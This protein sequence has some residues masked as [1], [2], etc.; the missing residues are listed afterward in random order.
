MNYGLYLS[1]AGMQA[2]QARQTVIS[3]NLANAQTTGFKRDLAVMRSRLN[4]GY[5]DATMFP[6]RAPVTRDQGGGVFAVNGGIDLSQSAL[7]DS[8]S[9]TDVAL[10][11]RGFFMVA[12]ENG[13]KLLTRDGNFLLNNEGTLVTVA[14]GREVLSADGQPIKLNPDLPVKIDG[15]G[16]I[17]QGNVTAAQLGLTNVAD[18]RRLRKIGG[19]LLTVDSPDALSDLPADTR[20]CQSKL[21][22]S[23]VEPV[24]EMVNMMEGQRAFEA[25][26]RMISF[27]DTTLSQLNTIGRVA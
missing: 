17:S 12:G 21:E 2:Q 14:D 3:N 26:A 20:V 24:V 13:Q 10:D 8:S 16:R 22:T 4:A 27:Q 23:G 5:E 7:K 1:A 11:G 19:N 25:N 15:K 18:S 9:A 6:Y